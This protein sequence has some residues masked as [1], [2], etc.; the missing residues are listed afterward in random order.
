M[1]KVLEGSGHGTAGA[2][3]AAGRI[4]ALG[5]IQISFM[6]LYED[7]IIPV[8]AHPTDAGLDLSAYTA[9]SVPIT[10]APGERAVVPTGVAV[11]VPEGYVGL[12]CPRSGLAAKHGITIT[13]AP[14]VIDSGYRGELKVVLQNTSDEPFTLEH[15]ARIAQ[16]VI[17]PALHVDVVEVTEFSSTDRGEGGFGST[18][19]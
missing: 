6:R 18:G 5:A 2:G 17:T 9:Q 13:N 1:G 10:L 15:E 16:L 11:A 8:R 14:G 4:K 3:L 19:T 7:A 12:V